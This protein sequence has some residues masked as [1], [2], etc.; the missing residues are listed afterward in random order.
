MLFKGIPEFSGFGYSS[1]SDVSYGYG[2]YSFDKVGNPILT[3]AME[4]VESD[5]GYNIYLINKERPDV[6]NW[7][8]G[9]VDEQAFRRVLVEKMGIENDSIS[10][11]ELMGSYLTQ[12]GEQAD[13]QGYS[14]A[15]ID[16]AIDSWRE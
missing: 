7:S 11:Y 2:F 3:M 6:L 16:E 10:C 15:Q 13:S 14:L 4:V 9:N 5:Y 12:I 1:Y 8:E